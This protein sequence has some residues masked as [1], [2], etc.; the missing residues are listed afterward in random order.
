MGKNFRNCRR[1]G[2]G[3]RVLI[4]VNEVDRAE[5]RKV[6]GSQSIWDQ[7]QG[8]WQDEPLVRGDQRDY[9]VRL[10]LE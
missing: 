4:L 8:S 1:S 5:S 10:V 7:I 6:A 2:Q 9:S 3:V